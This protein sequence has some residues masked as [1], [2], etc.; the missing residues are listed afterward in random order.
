MRLQ[1]PGAREV[2]M[3]DQWTTKMASRTLLAQKLLE[4]P[5]RMKK[6]GL[7]EKDLRTLIALGV[8]AQLAD[9]E[10]KAQ[11]AALEVNRGKR[12]VD[13]EELDA[14]DAMLK[15]RLP[16]VIE[17]LKT[18]DDEEKQYEG[19]WLGALSFDRYRYRDMTDADV[20]AIDE[21]LARR[22]ARVAR[23]DASARFDGLAALCA[24]LRAPG[25]EVILEGLA[26]R[27]VS[28]EWLEDVQLD[29]EAVVAQGRNVKKA[30]EAT[31]RE[32]E[33]ARGQRLK[34]AAA[35]RAVRTACAGSDELLLLLA[36]C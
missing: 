6:A 21:A 27:G 7:L 10:Q 15:D 36:D 32:E 23:R 34:W 16:L 26:E 3:A 18:S 11:I 33:A 31:A 28:A 17:D 1:G 24:A 29:A 9:R 30:A 22:V 14:A 8:A 25:H 20:V 4:Q 2:Q 5:E 13:A 19:K 35:R 12:K